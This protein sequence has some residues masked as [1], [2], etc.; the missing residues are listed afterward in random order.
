MFSPNFLVFDCSRNQLV[1][2]FVVPSQV[3]W[4]VVGVFLIANTVGICICFFLLLQFVDV[5]II[6]Y[7]SRHF[8]L[9]LVL[10]WFCR[11]CEISL[12]WG[13]LPQILSGPER[14]IT[15]Q[16]WFRDPQ[17]PQ[18]P[19]SLGNA[20]VKALRNTEMGKWLAQHVV[21]HTWR[22]WR[23]VALPRKDFADFKNP[24]L[25]PRINLF[26]VV[27]KCAFDFTDLFGAAG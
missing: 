10:L 15:W 24:V 4:V 25:Q 14:I 27:F 26:R 12:F 2:A 19:R 13:P 6:L 8:P 3:W 17:S 5:R 11:T 21:A 16:C 23:N 9:G 1:M 7:I 20:K 18:S 22:H